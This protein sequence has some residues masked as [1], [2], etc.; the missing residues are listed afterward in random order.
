MER[1][2]LR[3]ILRTLV[4]LFSHTE[5]IG[6][7][8]IPTEGAC[9]IASNHLSRLDVPIN[10]CV[11]E[12]DDVTGLA[13]DKYKKYP[14]FN[15]IVNVGGGIWLNRESADL[16]AFR[17]V[18]DHLANGGALGIA[19]EGTRSRTGALIAAKNGVAYLADKARVPIIP[20]AITGSESAVNELLHLRRPHITICFGRPFTLPPIDRHNRLADL[21]KN[22]DEI[23]CRIAVLLPEQHHGAYAHH[24]RFQELRSQITNPS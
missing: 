10:Y 12:R 24:P 4:D 13:A 8:N 15:W 18:L 9:L 3:K 19:P 7:E 11:I 5:V 1:K 20:M 22:T 23:M 14:L 21:Q 2:N 16:S 6:L 17:A